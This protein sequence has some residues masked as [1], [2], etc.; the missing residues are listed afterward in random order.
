MKATSVEVNCGSSDLSGVSDAIYVVHADQGG[1]D[2]NACGGT[3][4]TAC[5]TIEKGLSQCGFS[6]CDAVLVGYGKYVPTTSLGVYNVNLYG[7]CLQKSRDT[8]GLRSL[9]QAAPGG[10]PAVIAAGAGP[11][12]QM[13]NFKISASSA[14]SPGGSSIAFLVKD[15][16]MSIA[17]SQFYASYG[18]S[19]EK[20]CDGCITT[21]AETACSGQSITNVGGTP[22]SNTKGAFSDSSWTWSGSQGGDGFAG[23]V[24]KH[25]AL[26]NGGGGGKQGGGSFAVVIANA[27]VQISSSRIAGGRGGDGGSGGGN[28]V[29]L[30]VLAAL[31]AGAGGNG[32]PAIGIAT[33]GSG[34]HSFDSVV[35]DLGIGGAGGKPPENN[36]SFS[37]CL[38]GQDGSIGIEPAQQSF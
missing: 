11:L 24:L 38:Q 28:G 15:T 35:Y 21:Q 17:Q 27:T 30:A 25:G 32:G 10:A 31:G 22:S 26:V 19:G 9:I 4:A 16:R 8:T 12:M 1:Q 34:Q 5:A 14:S 37:A 33:V 29:A 6:R 18:G 7:G 20:G 2:S 23:Y 3:L 36:A 13:Q